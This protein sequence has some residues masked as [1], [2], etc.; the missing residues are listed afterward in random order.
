MS[1]L[2]GKAAPEF[3]AAAV[4]PNGS[5]SDG[6]SLADYKGK[7]VVLFFY[8]LDFT[9][10]CPTEILAFDEALGDFRAR[11][12]EVVGLVF[13]GNIQSLTSAYFYTDEVCRAVSVHSS[14]IR[15]A[16]RNIYNAGHL[17][18]QLLVDPLHED[19]GLLGHLE[20]DAGPAVL[21]QG[22]E[23]VAVRILV[24]RVRSDSP[25]QH[26]GNPV[27]IRVHRR[28]GTRRLGPESDGHRLHAVGV[29]EIDANGTAP[30]VQHVPMRPLRRLRRHLVGPIDPHHLGAEARGW[31]E[32]PR[33]L[34]GFFLVF[35]SGA[36]LTV[37]R[38]TQMAAAAII[39]ARFVSR[40]GSQRRRTIS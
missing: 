27:P 23:T 24:H 16:L 11:N 12:A 26:V 19:L 37:L 2:V 3:T 5:I 7:Y 13:D 22:G 20:L 38:E 34:P 36:L 4:M 25:F 30:P 15:E 17:A 31:L 29:L 9:F 18:D 33:E 1:V 32:F 28:A 8:P 21:V 39:E 35:I 10:V 14:A 40:T 6:L